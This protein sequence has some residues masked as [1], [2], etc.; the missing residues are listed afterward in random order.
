MYL[1]RRGCGRLLRGGRRC[2]LRSRRGC[3]SLGR[4]GRGGSCCRLLLRREVDDIRLDLGDLGD[5]VH[6]VLHGFL[7]RSR[8]DDDIETVIE[9]LLLEILSARHGLDD[10]AELVERVHDHIGAR[11]LQETGLSE[12][13]THM[14]GLH[15]R[16]ARLLDDVL[17][18]VCELDGDLV[19][20]RCCGSRCRRRCRLRRGLIR[21]RD[22]TEFLDEVGDIDDILCLT[23][24][25]AVD[26]LP[27][28]IDALEE[29]INDIL[30][31]L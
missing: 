8:D 11:G 19:F 23:V 13:H 17:I 31:E 10:I 2:F 27:E 18:D 14:D 25:D 3:C 29:R 9:L 21:F 16:L 4:R 28:G 26:H 5:R 15:A 20:R 6:C 7:L 1:L 12:R 24:A 30:V 22:G